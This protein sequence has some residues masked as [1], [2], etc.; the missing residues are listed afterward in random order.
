MEENIKNLE[1]RIESAL[2]YYSQQT[3]AQTREQTDK[4]NYTQSGGTGQEL[5]DCAK[6]K[7]QRVAP[8]QDSAVDREQ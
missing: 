1:A 4:L 7:V 5:G 8:E 3:R 6:W 2:Q